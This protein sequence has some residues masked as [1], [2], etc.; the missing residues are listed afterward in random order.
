M[1]CR[2]HFLLTMRSAPL[3]PQVLPHLPLSNPCP[4]SL[5]SLPWLH[6]TRWSKNRSSPHQ[7]HATLLTWKEPP[8][9]FF[10]A[11]RAPC[12]PQAPHRFPPGRAG[13]A[14]AKA[15]KRTSN[16]G[17]LQNFPAGNKP[18]QSIALQRGDS[19]D[20]LIPGVV[21]I[22]GPDPRCCAGYGYSSCL[23]LATAGNRQFWGHIL[24]VPCEGTTAL[25]PGARGERKSVQPAP[26]SP[27]C[28]YE[29]PAQNQ[30]AWRHGEISF[31]SPLPILSQSPWGC[32]LGCGNNPASTSRL[33]PV[34]PYK[35]VWSRAEPGAPASRGVERTRS[36]GNKLFRCLPPSDPGSIPA[37]FLSPKDLSAAVGPA[38]V[39]AVRVW[40]GW[41]GT[42]K[43]KL[44]P[45]TLGTPRPRSRLC[46]QPPLRPW[47]CLHS[48]GEQLEL[49]GKLFCLY[50]TE[51]VLLH[52]RWGASRLAYPHSEGIMLFNPSPTRKPRSYKHRA[53]PGGT[54]PSEASSRSAPT[55]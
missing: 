19:P 46:Q 27:D 36:Q 4:A 30:A 32:H 1:P 51:H 42:R 5:L 35:P 53:A 15:A 22:L 34:Q 18:R 38:F 8:K 21:R 12:P 31:L 16:S 28:L 50:S 43:G 54:S 25:A 41:G 3:F 29:T 7:N 2:D 44:L 24:A 33:D 20:E 55:N 23:G 49:A 37:K 40:A 13:S 39:F 52:P 48:P 45:G 17:F 11:W 10:C 9:F 47:P 6:N 26:T 14:G